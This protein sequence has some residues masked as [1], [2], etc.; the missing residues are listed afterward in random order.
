M[1]RK[2]LLLIL[3]GLSGL[4]VG[5]FLFFLTTPQPIAPQAQVTNPSPR[6]TIS[7]ESLKS[8]PLID[9]EGKKRTL[10]EWKQ[11]VLILNFWAPWCPPCRGEI[12]SLVTL[13]KEYAAQVQILGLGL[14]SAENI[15][16]FAAEYEMNYPS[17]LAT[18]LM[19]MYKVVF[20]N[21]SGA[22]PFTAIIDQERNIRYTHLGEI[23]LSQ[24][25]EE[26]AKIL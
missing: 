23:S 18:T 24:L 21:R 1:T 3:L 14:D 11:P 16:S 2:A 19:P 7:P 6:Q 17:F 5:I 15:A 13:Q 22:L 8:I 9:L 25:R 12:P 4:G 10:G 26:L 20:G